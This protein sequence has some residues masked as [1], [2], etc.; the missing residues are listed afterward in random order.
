M[1]KR[2][3][4]FILSLCI[5]AGMLP[6]VS[7]SATDDGY[8]IVYDMVTCE[9]YTFVRGEDDMTTVTY[10]DTKQM[11]RYHSGTVSGTVIPHSSYGLQVATNVNEWIALEINLPASG[12]YDLEFRHG[13]TGS[14]GA[15]AGGMWILP[16]DTE[17]IEAALLEEEAIATDICYFNAELGSS[18]YLNTRKFKDIK[19]SAGKHLVVYKALNDNP[20]KTEAMYPG[21]LTFTSG[22]RTVL[23]GI[24]AKLSNEIDPDTAPETSIEILYYTSEGKA[25]GEEYA[26]VFESTND[27][28]VVVSQNGTVTVVGYGMAEILVSV[29]NEVGYKLEKRIPVSIEKKGYTIRYDIAAVMSKLGAVY[30]KT[31]L[32]PFK[33]F[34]EKISNGF[35]SYYDSL[36]NKDG[37]TDSSNFNYR[38]GSFQIFSNKSK[39]VQR[40]IALEVFVPA[41]GLYRMDMY[42]VAYSDYGNV[43]VYLSRGKASVN[44]ADW[45]GKYD[46]KGAD[47]SFV[48][49]T[50]PNVIENI[51]IPERGYYVFTFKVD[52]RYGFVGTFDLISGEELTAPMAVRISGADSGFAEVEAY[53]SDGSPVNAEEAKIT[54]KSSNENVAE[55]GPNGYIIPKNIGKTTISVAVEANGFTSDASCEFEVTEEPAKPLGFAGVREE[56]NFWNVNTRYTAGAGTNSI[57]IRNIK[58]THTAPTGNGNW[59][60]YGASE[61]TTTTALAYYASNAQR[62]RFN[63]LNNG[64][65]ALTLNIPEAGKYALSFDYDTYNPYGGISE[66]HILPKAEASQLPGNLTTKNLIGTVDYLSGKDKTWGSGTKSLGIREF[67]E[68]GEYVIVFRQI[69]DR[70]TGYFFLESL[71]LDGVNVFKSLRV[72]AEEDKLALGSNKTT[73]INVEPNRMDVTSISIDACKT[74]FTSSD[75]KVATV[76][77]NGLVTAVSEG[78]ATI[79]VTVTADGTTLKKTIAI[80][81][82]DDSGVDMKKT[83]IDVSD[84]LYVRGKAELSLIAVMNS[85]NEIKVPGGAVTFT[86][87]DPS[88]CAISGKNKVSA[89]SEGEVTIFAEAIFKGEQIKVEQK[90]NAVLHEGKSKPTYYTYEKREAAQKNVNKYDWAKDLRDATNVLG[91]ADRRLADWEDIYER[92]P[93]EGIPRSR[94][95]GTPNDPNFN[96]CRYCGVDLVTKYGGYGFTV[97]SFERPWKV[98]CPDCK[99]VFPSNDFESFYKLGLDQKGYFDRQRALDKHAELFGD[100]TAEAGSDAYY[101]Y[102]KGYLKNDSYPEVDEQRTPE[103]GGETG[104]VVTING[105]K[106]LRPGESAATWGVDDGLGYIPKDENG[107]PYTSNASGTEIERHCYIAYYNFYFW[108]YVELRAITPL[109]KAYMYTGDVK[110]GRVG[111]ILLDRVADL[112]PDYDLVPWNTPNR[113]WM[114]TDG[115][116]VYGKIRGRISDCELLENFCLACDALYPMLQDAEVIKFLSE[117]AE[118]QGFENDKTDAS[119]IWENWKNGILLETFNAAKTK[120]IWGNFGMHQAAVGA[121]AVVLDEEPEATEM[122]EWLFATNPNETDTHNPDVKG[123]HISNKLIEEVDRDGLGNESGLHYNSIWVQRLMRVAEYSTQYK[124]E[125]NFNLYE[126]PKFL[127]MFTPYLTLVLAESHHAQI[128][129]SGATA[130]SDIANGDAGQNLADVSVFA[131]GF[132]YIK[133]VKGAE[134]LAQQLAQ[135]IWLRNGKD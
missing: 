118:E 135:Y 98:Q 57:D 19:L 129:D 90:I 85:G 132:R 16:G 18:I 17:N 51:E 127:K 59:E 83:Y 20:G 110:Y 134:S 73:Q 30:E 1:R 111:A 128:A 46:C 21:R 124:G 2:F 112:L 114:N 84:V 96:I 116:S 48:T 12:T 58:Y 130:H 60:W 25:S 105:G 89:V 122:F 101:G 126:H 44:E 69:S 23:G 97:A 99:R 123:G 107:K 50:T 131:E 109:A 117:K 7:V 26:P 119:K 63:L 15:L 31:Q 92:I 14:N 74:V 55:I 121:A 54:W 39:N 6:S 76:D 10:E 42:N 100:K 64:W 32:V 106:G 86:S 52:H 71:S 104:T 35:F 33:A 93:S 78:N 88:V 38:N 68:A 41:P 80:E 8:K 82:I 43:D 56:Y 125:K 61:D 29:E 79:T 115:V 103:N 47:K 34:N 67:S 37:Y 65:A 4:S 62:L 22:D 91:N 9:A 95:V 28:V 13:M 81:V 53:M 70:K 102:G 75:E 5:V 72:E 40:W 120:R 3:L 66:I 11:W 133:D 77:N 27:E 87:S 113:Q 45:I 24:E 94:H 108:G 36:G 49:V